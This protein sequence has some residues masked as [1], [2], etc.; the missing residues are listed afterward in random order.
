MVRHTLVSVRDLLATAGPFVLLTLLL[1]FGAYWLLDPDPPRRVVMATGTPRG[2]YAE[3]GAMYAKLL[4]NEGIKVELRNTQG[5]VENMA[6]LR[7]PK[8]GVDI[9]FV[10]GGVDGPQPTDDALNADLMSLGSLF[11]EPVWLFY[12]EDAALRLLKSPTLSN[13]AQLPGWR[14]NSGTEGSGVQTLVDQLLEANALDPL[15]RLMIF[16]EK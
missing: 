12:R 11:H 5:T 9:A 1:L 8:S 2:A 15:A 13:V 10:Q 7:D 14:V 4:A 16:A 6:L 3:F